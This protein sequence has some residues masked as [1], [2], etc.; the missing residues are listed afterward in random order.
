MYL[1]PGNIAWWLGQYP[2]P[3]IPL[4]EKVKEALA[5]QLAEHEKKKDPSDNLLVRAPIEEIP[6]ET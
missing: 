5:E 1:S 4:H 6:V 2:P 3:N